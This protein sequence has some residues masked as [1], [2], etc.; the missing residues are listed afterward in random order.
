MVTIFIEG[1]L[2][3]RELTLTLQGSDTISEVKA[4]VSS[5]IG[6]DAADFDLLFEGETA[7]EGQV[8]QWG[9]GEGDT[10]S[11]RAGRRSEARATLKDMR[12][13]C[14][15]YY[16][17]VRRVMMETD[18]AR[19][20]AEKAGILQLMVDCEDASFDSDAAMVA[21][22]EQGLLMCVQTLT[23][24]Y[25][26]AGEASRNNSPTPLYA[27]A[28]GR[29]YPIV[30]HLLEHGA[31]PNVLCASSGFTATTALHAAAAGGNS[32][33]V[34][35]LLHHNA[36]VNMND[37]S[38]RS[39]VATAY[40]YGHRHIVSTLLQAGASP[41]H[42][43]LHTAVDAED[44]EFAEFI[45]KEHSA[46]CSSKN[47]MGWTPLHVAAASGHLDMF[48]MLVSHGS[49]HLV[50]DTSGRTPLYV[51]A[52]SGNVDVMKRAC[53]LGADPNAVNRYGVTPLYDAVAGGRLPVVEA[54]LGL[55][56][57]PNACCAVESTPLHV[58]ADR[59]H[60]ELIPLLI[61]HGADPNMEVRGAT[62]LRVAVER[63]NLSAV[64][65]LIE[66]GAEVNRSTPLS[67]AVYKKNKDIVR[68]LL[69]HG[70]DPNAADGE[71]MMFIALSRGCLEIAQ[72]LKEYGA[73]PVENKRVVDDAD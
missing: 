16:D 47:R 71:S 72:L 10:V 59:G 51:A 38:S 2:V 35:L 12:L 44:I 55:G 67:S 61:S 42:D 32:E 73:R 68:Y 33:M 52:A 41:D 45:I 22:A 53:E 25:N 40:W 58:A 26:F 63:G 14:G 46:S 57:S 28:T 49:N 1:P 36:D 29:H 70:A 69:E 34:N 50:S 64:V 15:V 7:Q 62:P 31:R 65:S 66:A 13:S 48:N 30:K 20:D 4:M 39:P 21:A 54:L 37:S 18:I 9:V 60:V 24:V 3:N 6:V 11:V 27:A 8:A 23:P 19:S 17:V 5:A 56:V 43:L